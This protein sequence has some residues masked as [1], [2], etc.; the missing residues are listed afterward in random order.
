MENRN[1][2]QT[3]EGKWYDFNRNDT[4][5]CCDCSLVHKLQFKI[6]NGKIFIKFK[7]DNRATAAYRKGKEVKSK[8]KKL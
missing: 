5:I 6:V 8:I 2:I 3:F 1:Y 7:R 4:L